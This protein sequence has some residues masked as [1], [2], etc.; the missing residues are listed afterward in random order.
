MYIE[1]HK[2]MIYIDS[3]H[4]SLNRFLLLAVGLWPYQQSKLV[5]IQLILLIAILTSFNLF[6]VS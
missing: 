2:K 3:L 5:R 1:A 4:I 6:Q